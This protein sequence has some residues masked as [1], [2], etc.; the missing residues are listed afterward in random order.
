MIPPG[1]A[2]KAEETAKTRDY[3]AELTD[4][5]RAAEGLPPRE[6]AKA[7]AAPGE[8]PPEEKPEV[9]EEKEE[10]EEESVEAQD[11][12]TERLFEEIAGLRE[13]I[14]SKLGKTEPAKTERQVDAR[15]KAALESDDESIRFLAEQLQ[16]ANQRVEKV[17]SDARAERIARQ[18]IKD[19]ADFDDVRANYTIGGKPMTKA[20]VEEVENYILKN[21]EVGSRLTIEEATLVVFKGAA[22]RAGPKSPPAKGP[23]GSVNGKGSSVAT[24][25][26]EGSAGGV[27][28][29]PWKPRPNETIESAMK[30]AGER[31]L[32]VKR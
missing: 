6:P 1:A 8:K 11:A 20:H 3:Y 32:G 31:L 27:A 22:V 13:D 17:E 4:E 16:A 28:A 23:G 2:E 14:D 15:L 18:E 9:E 5:E 29:G 10:A 19:D 7:D 12:A 30:V 21:P 26:D 24:I 25:V